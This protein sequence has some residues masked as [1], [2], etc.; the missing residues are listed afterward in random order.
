MV[1]ELHG[2]RFSRGTPHP[3]VVGATIPIEVVPYGVYMD[4]AI[5]SDRAILTINSSLQSIFLYSWKDGHVHLV[6]TSGYR[7][8]RPVP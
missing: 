4:L 5:V 6:R 8:H 3:Y 7:N 1:I 2:I